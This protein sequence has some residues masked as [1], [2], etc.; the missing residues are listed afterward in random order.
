VTPIRARWAGDFEFQPTGLINEHNPV[1][2]VCF[3]A[4]NLDTGS[5]VRVWRDELLRMPTWPIDVGPDAM[6]VCYSAGA[7]GGCARVL[8]WPMPHNVLDLYAERLLRLNR[9]DKGR[10][11]RTSLLHTL[12]HYRLPAMA[13]TRKD[14]YRHKILSQTSW[15]AAEAAEILDYCGEDGD[16]LRALLRAMEAQEPINYPQAFWR[17]RWM[18]ASGMIEQEGIPI[19]TATYDILRS[20]RHDLRQLLIARGDKYNVFDAGVYKRDRVVALVSAWGAAI[21]RFTPTGRRRLNKDTFKIMARRDK[22]VEE[23]RGFLALLDQLRDMNVTLGDD[24]RN[25]FWSRPLRS[26]TARNQPSSSANILAYPK[27]M[28]G[29]VTPPDDAHALVVIDYSNQE[30]LIAAGQSGD[31][32]LAASCEGD[33]HMAV[34]IA[35]GWAPEGADRDSHPKVRDRAKPLNHGSAYGITPW[36][37]H[38]QTGVSLRE[39]GRMIEDYDHAFEVFRDGQMRG[40][41]TALITGEISTPLGWRM[42]V[43]PDTHPRTLMNWKLQ[44]IGSQ[45]TQIA[46]VLLIRAGYTICTTAHDSVM[47]LL[48]LRDDMRERVRR[49]QGIMEQVSITLTKGLRIPT[50]AEILSPGQRLLNRDTRPMW[51]L[52]MEIIGLAP[53]LGYCYRQQNENSAALLRPDQREPE[54]AR[55]AAG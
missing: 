37:I 22:R 8:G 18:F 26:I 10:L 21:D 38:D 24:A 39:A 20:R 12:R 53:D 1:T 2:P 15:T 30:T 49:A 31:A 50:N 6:F 40:V 23:L 42:A 33:R 32:A 47:L 9:E 4:S 13:A 45:M 52:V 17:G 55:H 54:G 3:C 19:D 5:Q 43:G 11:S 14:F 34:A 51:N 36:G 7:E 44:A 48:P 27:W 41:E 46:A 29:L 16:E 28:R 25:R 35:M